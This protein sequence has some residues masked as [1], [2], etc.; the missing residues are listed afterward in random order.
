MNTDTVILDIH[1]YVVFSQGQFDFD[2]AVF[3]IAEFNGV[4]NQVHHNLHE[5]VPITSNQFRMGR[6]ILIQMNAVVPD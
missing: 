4:G 3:L 2:P 6:K 5:S 1:P